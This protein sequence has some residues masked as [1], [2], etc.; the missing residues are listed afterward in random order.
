MDSANGRFVN[1][2]INNKHRTRKHTH[3]AHTEHTFIEGDERSVVCR[4]KGPQKKPKILN[5]WI[6]LW[7][8]RMLLSKHRTLVGW[9]QMEQEIQIHFA[10]KH[11]I[12]SQTSHT[13]WLLIIPTSISTAKNWNWPNVLCVPLSN[14]GNNKYSDEIVLDQ[15][16]VRIVNCFT[17]ST[18]EISQKIFLS[19][20]LPS[21]QPTKKKKKICSNRIETRK[22][23][24]R[25]MVKMEH[26][27]NT[28]DKSTMILL[29][30][31]IVSRSACRRRRR[32]SCCCFIITS[33]F[34]LFYFVSCIA[35][36]RSCLFIIIIVI[37]IIIMA[38]VE[39]DDRSE[40]R[41]AMTKKKK[42]NEE[43]Y[44]TWFFFSFLLF[45]LLTTYV[46]IFL[47]VTQAVAVEQSSRSRYG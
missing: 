1:T 28:I 12:T 42:K 43:L 10:R 27:K 33:L 24:K 36:F 6:V 26:V 31:I 41:R 44:G 9:I 40:V 34:S 25:K 32:R 15:L 11:H 17:P 4:E 47:F 14:I 8:W 3:I 46:D 38:N 20:F 16:H 5:K 30:N 35:F 39:W 37:I 19:I 22:I 23:R 7:L 18:T 29:D 21:S 13:Y 2:C 45:V